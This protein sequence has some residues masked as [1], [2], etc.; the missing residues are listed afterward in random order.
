MTDQLFKKCITVGF[1]PPPLLT[2]SQWA[3]QY[4]Q[5]SAEG[6][7]EPGKWN[8]TR[9]EYQ[10]GIMD[11][12]NEPGIKRIYVMTSSQVGKTEIELNII[13][14]FM[15]HDPCPLLVVYPTTTMAEA[16]SDD[17][18]VPMLRDTPVLQNL[19]KTGKKQ[20]SKNTKLHK[21]FP[22][23]HITLVGSNAPAGL[24]ARP[25][26]GVLFDEID[27]YPQSSG[28]RDAGEGDVISLARKRT[29]TFFNSFE[30]GVSTPTVKGLSRIEM[31]YNESD[32]RRYYVPCP[33]CGEYQTLNWRNVSWSKNENEEHMPETAVYACE[34][35]GVLWTEQQRH[36][37]VKRGKWV[38]DNPGGDTA[39]FF[40]NELYSPWSTLEKIVSEF[41]T[42]KTSPDRLRV[43]INTTL[44]ETFEE[45]TNEI[46]TVGLMGRREDYQELPENVGVLCMSVDVQDDRLEYLICGYADKNEI[47]AYQYGVIMGNPSEYEAWA[48]L[49]IVR[50]SHYPVAD[51]TTLPVAVTMI[52]TGYKTQE[53][54]E[55]IKRSRGRVYGS[56]GSSVVSSG[57]RPLI[58]KPSKNNSHRVNVY[59]IATDTGKDMLFARLAIDTPGPSYIHFNRS[60]DENFFIMLSAEKR[61][62]KFHKGFPRREW[63]KVAPRNESIDLFVYNFAAYAALNVQSVEALIKNRKPVYDKKQPEPEN[64][65]TIYEPQPEK[66]LKPLK[67]Q[68]NNFA[69]NW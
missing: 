46:D 23:G 6:A 65:P 42:A 27:R 67:S 18:L 53:C 52:D 28:G 69:K 50:T 1:N 32:K 36:G 30:I 60:F 62:T 57:Q 47:Y 38:A 39:G 48:D 16:F 31:A 64:L 9:A 61:V 45:G 20:G 11:A 66:P 51:G 17:R 54:Y 59:S 58:K 10:R 24:A 19:V 22:G 56:K 43:W 15:S 5:L 14:Y 8:T 35:C 12:L 44:G 33:E 37:A 21:Q 25:I 40:I 49:E 68:K 41:V 34:K 29:Q 4:R 55:Y 26:R 63:I 3:D 2:V 13:G 7:A